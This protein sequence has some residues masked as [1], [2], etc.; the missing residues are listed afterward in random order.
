[1]QFIIGGPDEAQQKERLK[2]F[3]G[4]KDGK[5]KMDEARQEL[6]QVSHAICHIHT[7]HSRFIAEEV[8]EVSQIFL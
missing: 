5:K 8:A 3:F 1:M 6:E 7:Y 4:V 2:F